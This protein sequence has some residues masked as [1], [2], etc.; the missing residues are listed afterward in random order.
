MSSEVSAKSPMR[1]P[2]K[3]PHLTNQDSTKRAL[4]RKEHELNKQELL[5]LKE[6]NLKLEA[7]AAELKKNKS[8]LS[9][10]IK[11]EQSLA[12]IREK[13][14]RDELNIQISLEKQ[15]MNIQISEVRN[16]KDLERQNTVKNLQNSTV[17]IGSFIKES[18]AQLNA[19]KPLNN[20]E[21]E[22]MKSKYHSMIVNWNSN[23]QLSETEVL[24]LKLRK[25]LCSIREHSNFNVA[26]KPKLG[27]ELT[28][29]FETNYDMIPKHEERQTATTYTKITVAKPILFAS[30]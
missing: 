12:S 18:T 7:K 23:H 2:V 27:I 5:N 26:P 11:A 29:S 14:Y 3:S 24:N 28:N 17:Q 22:Q 4:K 15:K 8:T 6:Q 30:Q 13:E 21:V 10:A 16:A 9:H 25:T 20:E 19:Y 1:T